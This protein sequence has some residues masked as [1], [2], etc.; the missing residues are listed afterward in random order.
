M[1]IFV[2]GFERCGTH[3]LTN[4]LNHSCTV[5]HW[6]EHEPKP[7]LCKEAYL[8]I[9]QENYFTD[10]YKFKFK[11]YQWLSN[12]FSVVSEANHRLGY[13]IP[14]LRQLPNVKFIICVRNIIDVL[15]SRIATLA[16][17]PRYIHLYPDWFLKKI[18][19]I[20]KP[21]KQEFNNFR[22]DFFNEKI[23]KLY[24][25][26]FC[27]FLMNYNVVFS[28]ILDTDYFIVEI[29]KL[30]ANALKLFDF[31]GDKFNRTK[32]E[33]ILKIKHDSIYEA[34][35]RDELIEFAKEM[36]I[37]YREKILEEFAKVDNRW[38]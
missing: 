28:N 36:I 13:F 30:S 18:T 11:R 10:E 5:P 26:Y 2:V 25:L 19:E 9:H 15:I 1:F 21:N 8:K 20:V 7:T 23:E 27:E 31:L 32:A 38:C 29:E 37:P 6:I 33:S 22:F 35:D 12:R 34:S 14:D 24:Q 16:H 17:Y 3:S 4:I